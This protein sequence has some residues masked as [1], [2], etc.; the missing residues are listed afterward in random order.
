[1]KK[2]LIYIT[3]P[4]VIIICLLVIIKKAKISSNNKENIL[5]SQSIEDEC[6]QEFENEKIVSVVSV[7]E[8]VSADAKLI[9]KKYYRQCDHTINEAVEI[10]QEIINMEKEEVERQYPDWKVIG[11]EQDKIVLY[12]E[13][14][15]I[16]GEHYKLKAENGRINIYTINKNGIETLYQRTDIPSEYLPEIDLDQMNGEGLEVDGK[17]ELN[18]IIEDFE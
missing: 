5:I 14:E 1:M 4:L 16:C 10:P 17:Q 12:K 15:D 18:R 2:I 7:K 3:L 9:L 13:F 11:F 8:K 6:T